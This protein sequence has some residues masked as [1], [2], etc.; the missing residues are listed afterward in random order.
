[1]SPLSRSSISL[2]RAPGTSV[3]YSVL[4]D[5]PD[6]QEA[7]LLAHLRREGVEVRLH[8]TRNALRDA[9]SVAH[10][11][12]ATLMRFHVPDV[13]E[14]ERVIYLDADVIVRRDLAA[15]YEAD[16]HGA[17]MGGVIDLPLAVARK[18][19]RDNGDPSLETYFVEILQLPRDALYVNAGV[20]VM[21]IA[22]L[23]RTN[24]SEA[25]IA[26]MRANA[27]R[28]QLR[29]QDV[30]N[31]LLR[32]RLCQL[33]PRWNVMMTVERHRSLTGLDPDLLAAI[34]LQQAEP[35]IRH[36]TNMRKPW[37]PAKTKLLHR[38]I[39]CADAE[40]WSYARRS[41]AYELLRTQFPAAARR[42]SGTFESVRHA[43][44]R[45]RKLPFWDS[46][47]VAKG[48][49]E[50]A[51]GSNNPQHMRIP[52][53]PEKEPTPMQTSIPVAHDPSVG[54]V[55]NS[56][57]R[58]RIGCG[59]RP[60]DISDSDIDWMATIKHAN[61]DL[62]APALWTAFGQ[63]GLTDV[64][65]A[66]VRDYL[67]L[68]HQ[69]NAS[70]NRQIREQCEEIGKVLAS[71]DVSAVLLKGAAWLFEAGPAREDRMLRDIDLL[72]DPARSD[73]VSVALRSAGYRSAHFIAAEPGHV[74]DAPLVHPN[75]IV[76]VE[77]HR[78]IT[79][80]VAL[81][82]GAEVFAGSRP[83]MAGLRMASPEH[84][85]VHNVLHSQIVN[86]DYVGG[87]VSLR[88]TLDLARLLH[89]HKFDIDGQAMAQEAKRR[90][91][92]RHLSGAIHKAARFAGGPLPSPFSDD[93]RGRRHALRCSIQRRWR[94]I[95]GPMRTVGV[96]HRAVAWE[97][98]SYA[99]GLGD[100][101]SLHA[102]L[103]VN[104]RRARRIVDA[105]KRL[106][107]HR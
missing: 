49:N 74:H 62:V 58:K 93:P 75:G 101:R 22:E 21:D 12:A 19:A 5:G 81:L 48:V 83:L 36:F 4:Y 33:D 55:T 82:S 87:V 46:P 63:A 56:L 70:S 59:N 29:D 100:D 89:A 50:T 52:E 84:R 30:I 88:D 54:A 26:L 16:L 69:R 80:R 15:L 57:L 13:I 86:G 99:I 96:L 27:R 31:V 71:A 20:L 42:N 92:F 106:I 41:P 77:V 65:P 53:S 6:G 98:D 85:I 91:Y 8:R 47:P 18:Q 32:N 44:A 23:R 64:L 68:L 72:I 60:E 90:G 3:V 45:A 61:D 102:H 24:F 1:M 107:Q 7:A 105:L 34:R 35:W 76:T 95:D 17:A 79:T 73:T 104:Q 51:N 66:D 38:H 2:H 103:E 67:D 37:S 78:D 39:R 11:T 28:F 43:V 94:A 14:A 40:W 9:G 97:R 10:V 25:A